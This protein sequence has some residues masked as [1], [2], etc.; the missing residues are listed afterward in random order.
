MREEQGCPS[1]KHAQDEEPG[2]DRPYLLCVKYG[3]GFY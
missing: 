2:P 1:C 3:R